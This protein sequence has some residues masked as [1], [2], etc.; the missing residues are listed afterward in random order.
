MLKSGY[1]NKYVMSY[2]SE[3]R[4]GG[5][6]LNLLSILSGGNNYIVVGLHC[7]YRVM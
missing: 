6:D 2:V 7:H 3:G 5:P 4:E 1:V